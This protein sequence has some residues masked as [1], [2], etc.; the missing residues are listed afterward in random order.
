MD[1]GSKKLTDITIEDV[2]H[3]TP[4]QKE[5][6]MKQ[7]L[8]AVTVWHSFGMS[9]PFGAMQQIIDIELTSTEMSQEDTEFFNKMSD[10]LALFQKNVKEAG[11]HARSQGIAFTP[12]N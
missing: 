8:N 9:I 7:A 3:L 10:M 11:K 1:L 12:Q 2:Q 5:G 4:G 6:F